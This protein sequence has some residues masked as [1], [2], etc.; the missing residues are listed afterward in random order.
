MA[1]GLLRHVAGDRF[2]VVSAGTQPA[3]LS[4]EAVEVLGEIGVDISHHRSKPLEPFLGRRVDYVITVCD[5]AKEACPSYPSVTS[6][7][8]WSLDDPAAAQGPHEER[9]A[10]FR[11]V[12]DQIA[13]R[14]RQ[15]IHDER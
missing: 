3:G 4:P 2:E 10:V 14:I 8:H 5:R 13:E 9:K 15:F 1:E 12:R 7:L 11:R 6:L